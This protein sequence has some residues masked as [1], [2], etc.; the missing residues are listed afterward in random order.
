M[1]HWI[2]LLATETAPEEAGGLFDINATLPLMA[3]Q[4]LLL[5]ALLN[6]VLFKPLSKALDDRDAY[7]RSNQADAKERLLKA[8]SL[9]KQ[10]EK[11]LAETRRQSQAVIA[12][13]QADAQRIAADKV[14][15]AQREAQAKREQTQKELDQQREAAFQSLEHEVESLGRQIM[16]KVLGGVSL[17]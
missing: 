2:F 12:E 9:A 11:E 16:D 1:I 17:G 14:A 7:V 13:A 5:V 10:Y 3:I 6:V 8:E 4:F 15:E